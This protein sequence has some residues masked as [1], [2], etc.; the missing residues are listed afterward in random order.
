MKEM[1]KN[2]NAHHNNH[3]GRGETRPFLGVGDIFKNK[4]PSGTESGL[5][6]NEVN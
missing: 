3:S 4:S 1:G 5:L 6:I 2:K